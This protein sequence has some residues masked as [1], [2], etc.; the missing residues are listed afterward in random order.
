MDK[1]IFALNNHIYADNNKILLGI[2][3]G[4]QQN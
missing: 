2:I 4:L 3:K 1:D